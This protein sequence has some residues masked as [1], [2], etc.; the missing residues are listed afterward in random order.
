MCTHYWCPVV[1]SGLY[2]ACRPAGAVRPAL[3]RPLGRDGPVGADSPTVHFP[4][5][6]LPTVT[7][8]EL[9]QRDQLS[10]HDA[11]IKMGTAHEVKLGAPHI[12]SQSCS[13][14]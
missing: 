6:H 10:C 14:S 3:P 12:A 8:G 5:G 4:L 1:F 9:A 7:T 11:C 13:E 2:D